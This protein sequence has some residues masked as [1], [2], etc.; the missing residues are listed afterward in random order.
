M[1]PQHIR[2]I[3]KRVRLSTS[4]RG[5]ARFA[6]GQNLDDRVQGILTYED[7]TEIRRWA[8]I[9]GIKVAPVGWAHTS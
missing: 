9:K 7:R 2:K 1:E 4:L 8:A 5:F 6:L 3:W